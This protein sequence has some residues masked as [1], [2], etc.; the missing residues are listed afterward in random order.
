[1]PD[2]KLAYVR[3]FVSDFE[4]AVRFYTETLGMKPGFRSD[5]MRWCQFET[6]EAKL[7]IEGSDPD[8]DPDEAEPGTRFA[9]VSLQVDDVQAVYAELVAKGVEFLGP[10]ERMEWGGTLAHFKDP[11]GNVLTLLG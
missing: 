1:M 10:P 8:D 2:Y 5:E 9:A 11:D 3:V 7:A 6:G 4:R